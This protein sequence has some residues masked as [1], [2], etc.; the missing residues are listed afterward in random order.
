MSRRAGI[1]VG[2]CLLAVGGLVTV[3]GVVLLVAF[4]SADGLR[5]G[6]H[7]LTTSSRALVS[8]AAEISNASA[9]NGVLGETRIDIQATTRGGAH[10]AFVGI[11]P[12]A[13]VDHYLAGAAV[14]V[15]TDF[16]VAP[17]RLDT[18]P[19]PGSA[20]ISAPGSQDFWVARGET[21]SGTAALSWTVRDGDY[22]FVVMNADGTPA[23]NVDAGFGVAVK[24]ARTLGLIVLV[25]GFVLLAAGAL[26]LILGLRAPA[27][28]VGESVAGGRQEPTT[29][30]T[31][32]GR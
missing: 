9:A 17:F 10:G 14:E 11:G 16:E 23:V 3:S 15:V 7:P 12:A 22:R 27:P 28:P 19:R 21:G 26:A 30:P 5:T 1:I 13:A 8:S 32:T 20:S 25:V 6:P 24:G 4:G 31:I 29:Q 2:C 18:Q